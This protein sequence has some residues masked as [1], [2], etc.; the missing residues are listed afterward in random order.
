[1][2]GMIKRRR[3]K[4]R[5]KESPCFFGKAFFFKERFLLAIVTIAILCVVAP[6]SL[7]AP[8]VSVEPSYQNVLQ[9]DIF[10]AN[11][12]V[13][14]N[15]AEI[16]GAQY[17]LYFNN[18]LLNAIEQIKGPFLTQDGASTMEVTNTINNTIGKIEY[19]EMRTGVEYGVNTSGVLATITFKAMEPG[20]SGLSL[21]NVILSDPL[22]YQISG[23]LINNGTVEINETYF[24]VTGFV[25]YSDG[26]PVN[27]PNVTI[28]NL[29]TS[30]VFT[31]ETNA[32]SNYYQLLTNF[33]HI[34]NGNILHFYASDDTDNL[35][36]FD[37]TITQEEMDA[38]GFV[39]NITIY[40]PDTTPPVITNISVIS[41]TKDSVTITWE[42]DEPS[43]SLVKYG[44]QSGNYTET[45]YNASDVIH[46]SI[47]FTELTINTTYYY[48]VNST[49]PS[50]NS[51]QSV[52]Q[53]FKTFD[54][55]TI[56][57]GDADAP[58]GENV[59]TSII[60]SNIINVGTAD[61]ILTYN[62]LVVH[63]IAVNGSDFDFMDATI[64][65]SSGITRI[66]TFQTSS[67]GLNGEV[68]LA[69]VT[70]KA[71]GIGGESC[72]L[73]LIINE[74]KEAGPEETTIP[75]TTHNGTFTIIETTPPVVTNPTANPASIPEDTD[76]DPGWGEIS[77]LNVTVTDDCGVA[78]VTINL[79]SIDGSPN[80]SMIRIPSTDIWSVNV[81][82][83]LGMAMC[84]NE[85]Y[86]PHN[87]T[88][89]ATDIFGNTNTSVNIPLIVILNGD[90][91]ENGEVSLYDA[92]YLAKHVLGK[93]GFETMNVR[94]GE[95]SGNSE[96]TLYDAMYL[97]KHVLGETGFETL[98]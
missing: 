70:L 63:V 29:N 58:V 52:E 64:D 82:A 34:N 19:G 54:E 37:H 42:T 9:G 27:N 15:G 62:Q 87:L 89:C 96:V 4:R 36:E 67:S 80:Q 98:H 72:T 75:A 53:S 61:I 65:N 1:M 18:T 14:P 21:S 45:A 84:Y 41:I 6:P 35:T 95:V 78:S 59:T 13:D 69:N 83:S 86:I 11:I 5:Q 3:E 46:H 85:S 60:I 26:S 66:G 16:F 74:L 24:N 56:R 79:S 77:Q 43:D 22:G 49:D 68:K 40:I 10:T 76:S 28:T 51:A 2:N 17:D 55:I 7:A 20:T 48:V 88:I 44:T 73:N 33:A 93:T 47:I 90:A 23:V 8:V 32:S 50:N 91:S 25:N 92:M 39:Q 71:V 31:A 81:N 12:T 30:E 38:S 94:V 57:I 97:A